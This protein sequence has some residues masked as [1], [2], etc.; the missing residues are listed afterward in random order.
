MSKIKTI[1]G[2][3]DRLIQKA[4]GYRATIVNGAVTFENG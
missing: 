3:E 1:R 2:I 4:E